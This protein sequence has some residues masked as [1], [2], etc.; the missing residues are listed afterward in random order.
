MFDPSS[1]ILVVDDMLTMRKIVER[2]LRGL[3]FTDITHAVDGKEALDKVKSSEKNFDLIISD[4]NMP[5]MSGLDF[6]KAVRGDQK[7]SQTPFLLVTAEAEQHQIVEAIKAGVDQ[8]VIKPF[9]QDSLKIKL[10][11]AHKKSLARKAV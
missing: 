4:W 6:L 3:G 1:K 7:Y 2:V 11:I 5:N 10:E 9:S 8:Y